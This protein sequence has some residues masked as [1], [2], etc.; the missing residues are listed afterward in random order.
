MAR[1]YIAKGRGRAAQ[2]YL[3]GILKEYPESAA[4]AESLKILDTLRAE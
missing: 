3:R 4:A 1:F 2:L